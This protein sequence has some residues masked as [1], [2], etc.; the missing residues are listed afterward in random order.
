MT[1]ILAD[2]IEVQKTESAILAGGIK[3]GQAGFATD[4]L[5]TIQRIGAA[6]H[7]AAFL[8]AENDFS[9][10]QLID[11]GNILYFGSRS[12]WNIGTPTSSSC[13]VQYNTTKLFSLYTDNVRF[14]EGIPLFFGTNSWQYLKATS[15]DLELS[16]YTDLTISKRGALWTKYGPTEI[17]HSID[18]KN[19]DNKKFKFSDKLEIYSDGNKGI[20]ECDNSSSIDF[21]YDE[22]IILSFASAAGVTLSDGKKLFV[23]NA[24]EI[25][26]SNN[27]GFINIPIN[28]LYIQTDGVT[29][30]KYT[31]S[32]LELGTNVT[33]Q[34]STNPIGVSSETVAKYIVANDSGGNPI[35]L[36]VVE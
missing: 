32:T 8:G 17:V 13:D 5:R 9:A 4:T 35:K 31:S 6:Y 27:N 28:E 15:S 16:F 33:F 20:I 24:L 14:S 7:K 30:L 29:V 11:G 18:S 19:N 36:A 3:D 22:D 21:I 12:E 25:Y 23:S 26:G 34:F 1:D 2:V 10:N